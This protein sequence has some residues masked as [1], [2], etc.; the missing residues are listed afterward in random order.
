MKNRLLFL[1][2]GLILVG[3]ISCTPEEEK[4]NEPQ[5]FT[6]GVIVTGRPYAFLNEQGELMGLEPELIRQTMKDGG[7]EMDMKVLKTEEEAYQGIIDG[8]ID[9][10]IGRIIG[11][12][13]E[14]DSDSPFYYSDS[15][16][17]IYQAV[18]VPTKT[19]IKR[20]ADLEGYRVGVK[21]DSKSDAILSAREGVFVR[22]YAQNS[23]AVEALLNGDLDAV[24]MGHLAADDFLA[25]HEQE[26]D[27][28]AERL[29]M[30]SYAVLGKDFAT[31][32]EFTE[33]FYRARAMGMVNEL[34]K[35][36]HADFL[37]DDK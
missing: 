37:E 33:Q 18:L 11:Q 29:E 8:S 25:E 19:D 13:R 23:E 17:G 10:A 35:K 15:Y 9:A 12:I 5:H 26:L 28:L 6:V 30:T 1:L 7:N 21:K 14:D 27:E 24:A 22:R 20:L 32:Y 4:K 34:R 36:Y 2:S 16:L 31:T 3:L